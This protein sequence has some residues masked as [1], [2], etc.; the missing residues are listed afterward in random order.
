MSVLSLWYGLPGAGKSTQL[1][2]LEAGGWR[3]FDDFMK[4]AARPARTFAASRHAGDIVAALHR[5]EPCAIADIRLCLQPFRTVVT[6]ALGAQFPALPLQWNVFDCRTPDAVARCRANVLHRSGRAAQGRWHALA[7][8][9]LHRSEFTVEPGARIFPVM[10]ARLP[11][12]G[13]GS[14]ELAAGIPVAGTNPT[15]PG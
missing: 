8:I 12:S 9:A 3:T 1:R 2:D 10:E 15:V 4:N 7:W 11:A 13:D 6:T 14:T 5:G